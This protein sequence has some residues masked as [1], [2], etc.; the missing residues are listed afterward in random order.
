M[1]TAAFQQIVSAYRA[2]VFST[3]ARITGQPDV[4]ESLAIDVF[5]RPSR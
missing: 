2:A 4:V 3:I 5:V 1:D